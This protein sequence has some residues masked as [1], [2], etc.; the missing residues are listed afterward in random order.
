M[1]GITISMLV[2]FAIWVSSI[3]GWIMNILDI[4]HTINDPITGLFILRC[5]GIIVA[6]LGAVLGLFV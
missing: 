1:K 6:P 5:V 2:M 3:V 4:V